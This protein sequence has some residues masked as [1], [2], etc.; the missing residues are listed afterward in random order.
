MAGQRDN[1]LGQGTGTRR[2]GGQGKKGGRQDKMSRG[3][4]EWVK[5]R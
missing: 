1:Q 5:K 2:A 4:Y 3:L